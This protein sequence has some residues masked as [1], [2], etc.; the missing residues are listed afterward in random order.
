MGGRG[1]YYQRGGFSVYEYEAT[2]ETLEGFKVIR[3]K[4][5]GHASLPQ[6]SNTPG[7][8]YILQNGDGHYKSMGIYGADRRLRKQ[9]DIHR[10]HTNRYKSGKRVV[11]KKGVAHVHN[12]RGGRNSNVRYMTKKEIKKYGKAIVLMG[13]KLHE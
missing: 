7:T 3:H 4:T 13:G 8:V 1:A 5:N 2:G 11:L 10:K 9:I 12:W 6:M